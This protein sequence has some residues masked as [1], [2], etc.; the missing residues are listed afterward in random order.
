MSRE[1]EIIVRAILIGAG[2]TAIL[3]LW[4]VFLKRCFAVPS[5][6]WGMVGR[7][8]GHIPRGRFAH[9]S[10]GQAAPIRGERVLGW[11]AHYVIGIVFT[12][13]L[14]WVWGLDWARHP[15]L[16]PAL[17]VGVLTVV[18]PFFLMQ[19]GMGAGIAASKTPNPSQARLRSLLTHTVFGVSMYVAALVTML[20][21]Q[22]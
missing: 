14:L 6:N 19:P 9:P 8:L 3:D 18:F 22:P 1:L 21:L 15:T 16:P 13:V 10:I 12:S 2:A 4:A 17:I 11:S 7:W 20:L 5:A